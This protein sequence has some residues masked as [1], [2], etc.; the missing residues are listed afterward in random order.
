[1]LNTI[2][3]K[4]QNTAIAVYVISLLMLLPYLLGTYYFAPPSA[5]S[6]DTAIIVFF[7]IKISFI[8]FV[9]CSIVG[10]VFVIACQSSVSDRIKVLLYINSGLAF[11]LLLI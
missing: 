5:E 4:D 10:S 2:N 8:I 3:K 6:G 9:F 11:I 7:L 1:M